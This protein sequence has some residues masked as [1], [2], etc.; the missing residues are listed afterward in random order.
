M[1]VL[2]ERGW[3]NRRWERSNSGV[4]NAELG[5]NAI[6]LINIV[7]SHCVPSGGFVVLND[8]YVDWDMLSLGNWCSK[9]LLSNKRTTKLSRGSILQIKSRVSFSPFSLCLV[10][11]IYLLNRRW[12]MYCCRRGAWG[13]FYCTLQKI[14]TSG[15]FVLWNI[16]P[17]VWSWCSA[18]VGKI[19]Q[20]LF[21]GS[22][23]GGP[24]RSFDLQGFFLPYVRCSRTTLL[25]YYCNRL[26]V[27]ASISCYFWEYL[28]FRY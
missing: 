20:N 13:L 2:F 9:T 27:A 1:Q 7:Y 8:K 18:V 19:M 22:A 17:L 26:S 15:R 28:L 24:S 12:E 5:F 10:T 6:R 4:L 23:E 14:L 25:G 21:E 16:F 3:R 11:V